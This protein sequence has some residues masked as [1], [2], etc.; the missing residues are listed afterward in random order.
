MFAACCSAPA[1]GQDGDGAGRHHRTARPPGRPQPP[2]RLMGITEG[3][4]EPEPELQ[5]GEQPE[6]AAVLTGSLRSP[7]EHSQFRNKH[8]LFKQTVEK[9]RQGSPTPLTLEVRRDSLLPDSYRAFAQRDFM[10]RDTFTALVNLRLR[11]LRVKFSGE[12]GVDEGGVR[13]EY[14]GAVTRA[15]CDPD[16]ALFKL[17]CDND[18]TYQIN[19]CSAINPDHLH[20]F[21]L[22][23]KLLAMAMIQEV[24]T[25]VRFNTGF[26]KQLLGMPLE[27]D[28]LESI[29]RE[30]YVSMRW[31]QD[32]DPAD[33]DFFFSTNVDN[34]GEVKEVDLIEDGRN[35]PVTE[36]NKAEFIAKKAEWRMERCVADQM[37]AIRKGFTDVFRDTREDVQEVEVPR[38][39]QEGYGMSIAKDGTVARW[40]DPRPPPTAGEAGTGDVLLSVRVPSDLGRNRQMQFEHGGRLVRVQVPHGVQDN[41]TIR[42][43]VPGL[44]PVAADERVKVGS[45]VIAV[46]GTRVQNK[47]EII[48]ALEELAEEHETVNFTFRR[49]QQG[50]LS[51]LGIQPRELELI[52]HGVPTIDLDDWQ[53]HTRYKG[54]YDAQSPAVKWFWSTLAG[55]DDEMQA[56]VLRFVTGTSKVPIDGFAQLRGGDGPAPFTI[57][58]VRW[59]DERLPQAATC[60]NT[61]YL[62]PYSYEMVLRHKLETAVT[63]AATGFALK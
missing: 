45:R 25:E 43:K 61:L 56:A 14:L 7:G 35:V 37:D 26:Y 52:M 4:L 42:V 21:E 28:D 41:D 59:P 31:I 22:F 62:P 60:V 12:P 8:G 51:A 54:R 2:P 18:Y 23:G 39:A 57:Q 19:E 40:R 13:R 47:D 16:F 6:V 48:A 63:E 58:S 33:M 9:W 50:I 38:V 17:T 30:L 36:E 32:N 53:K 55:W 15:F 20:F 49:G 1:A 46:N 3:E 11:P 44:A 29:D 34:F 5:P 24:P 10:E 27:F